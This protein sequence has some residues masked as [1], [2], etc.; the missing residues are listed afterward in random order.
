MRSP[1]KRLSIGHLMIVVAIVSIGLK[2]L[3][4]KFSPLF[5]PQPRIAV[6]NPVVMIGDIFPLTKGRQTWLVRNTG[7]AP[8]VMWLEDLND[9]SLVP[10]HLE[11]A[12]VIDADGR[13]SSTA[14]G[15]GC[16]FVVGPGG[17]ATI[18][19]SWRSRRAP[20]V[21]NNYFSFST[22]DPKQ[23]RLRLTMRGQVIQGNPSPDADFIKNSLNSRRPLSYPG[24]PQL[25]AVA[26]RPAP[27]VLRVQTTRT[28]ARPA[29]RPAPEE[30]A[31]T[32]RRVRSLP[33]L[34]PARD[35]R[36]RPG[37][38]SRQSH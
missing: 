23:P 21:F 38:E 30:T 29:T 33:L 19:M 34:H 10:N 9:C 32:E 6:A 14:G 24:I 22:N 27:R 25:A 20:C 12:T 37:D 11:S 28:P 17:Q 4:P 5:A 15:R 26:V 16:H 35:A 31:V 13:R 3:V 2:M 18:V 1:R 36:R 7:E 8:L